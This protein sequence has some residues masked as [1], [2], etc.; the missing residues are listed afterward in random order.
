MERRHKL[1]ITSAYVLQYQFGKRLL[2]KQ[3]TSYNSSSQQQTSNNSELTNNCQTS[4]NIGCRETNNSRNVQGSTPE[5]QH[6]R[7]A[8]ERPTLPK[9]KFTQY[10]WSGPRISSRRMKSKGV[11]EYTYKSYALLAAGMYA[12]QVHGHE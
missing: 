11:T 8:V 6:C 1:G 5:L 3:L 7:T 10:S 2:V 9:R 12:A 4:R